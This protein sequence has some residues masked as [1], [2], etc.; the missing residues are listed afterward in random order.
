MARMETMVRQIKPSLENALIQ[1]MA[2]FGWQVMSTQEVANSYEKWEDGDLY[3]VQEKYVKI[4]FQ[5]DKDM[6]DY[7]EICALEREFED[8]NG[9]IRQISQPEKPSFP[10]LSLLIGIAALI[11]VAGLL[12]LVS[13]IGVS[14]EIIILTSGLAVVGVLSILIG[15]LTYRGKKKRFP[16]LVENYQT[17][18]SRNRNAEMRLREIEE[19]LSEIV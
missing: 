18:V 7:K 16:G 8:V 15:T 2:R 12:I 19:R 17:I 11:G 13:R 6:P 3:N 10:A 5:R 1:S 14:F 9:S 4:T